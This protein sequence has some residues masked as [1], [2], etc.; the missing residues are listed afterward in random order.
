[1]GTGMGMTTWKAKKASVAAI[2]AALLLPAFS[3]AHVEGGK[4]PSHAGHA[5]SSQENVAKAALDEKLGSRIPLDITFRDES[6][7]KVQLAQVVT[8]PTIIVPVY[9]RCSNV[10]SQLQGDL[11]RVL[12]DVRR[13]P[14]IDYRVIS[15]S[16]DETESPDLAARAKRT[17]LAAINAPFPATGW[18]FLTG[19]AASIRRLTDAAGFSF[20]RQGVE[21][22][23]PIVS[24]VVSGDG[25]IVRYLYGSSFLAKDVT[26]AL[27]EAGQGKVGTTMR[28]V[29]GFC[30]S[31]D[32]AKKS[33][34]LNLLRICGAAVL[35]CVGSF[36]LYL[37][38][39]GNRRR[40]HLSGGP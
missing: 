39:T 19:D 25:M 21:F 23:H 36:F 35:L 30:F 6:G 9:Y 1:M 4:A 17:Y 14:G 2:L 3:T 26:L 31:F 13:S 37:V 33:Y 16:I 15:L 8:G 32:T 40:G 18:S 10:C 34:Q 22:I 12:P 28:K 5:P 7:R 38:L 24:F 20:Q 27:M 11:A 29:V